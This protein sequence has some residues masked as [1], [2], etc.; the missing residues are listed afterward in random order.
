MPTSVAPYF[1]LELSALND[2]ANIDISEMDGLKT[3]LLGIIQ[4]DG[5]AELA[6]HAE[7]LLALLADIRQLFDL[8]QKE[9]LS[10]Q[11]KIKED[12]R[13]AD[14][15]TRD[16]EL[17]PKQDSIRAR[18]LENEQHFLDVKYSCLQFFAQVL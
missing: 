16:S 3:K 2:R 1:L 18:M 15:H 7:S 13:P 8:T 9:I 14:I 12:R 11:A 5:V 10:Q 6:E 17:R 4:R